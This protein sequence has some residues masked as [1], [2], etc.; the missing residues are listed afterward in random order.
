VLDC[1]NYET[2]VSAARDEMAHGATRVIV[3]M[4]ETDVISLAG[5]IGLYLVAE[6]SEESASPVKV[7]TQAVTLDQI[8][9]WTLIGRMREAILEGRSYSRMLIVAH[10]KRLLRSLDELGLSHLVRT[11]PTLNDAMMQS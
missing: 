6:L 2:L 8:D 10:G 3:D 7:L 11:V 1:S 5:A 4:S 9:G